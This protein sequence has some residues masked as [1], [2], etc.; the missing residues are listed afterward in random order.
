MNYGGINHLPLSKPPLAIV[1][2]QSGHCWPA[3]LAMSC[4]GSG[5]R[6]SGNQCQI[7]MVGRGG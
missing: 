5:A 7:F 3:A 4:G 2:K 1:L 6:E